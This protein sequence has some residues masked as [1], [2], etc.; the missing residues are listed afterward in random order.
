[1]AITDIELFNK[2]CKNANYS[3]SEIDS[4][5][6]KRLKEAVENNYIIYA[7]YIPIILSG[8]GPIVRP[9]TDINTSVIN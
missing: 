7:P 8:H 1:M 3:Q 5:N 6:S 4:I 2:L 9:E